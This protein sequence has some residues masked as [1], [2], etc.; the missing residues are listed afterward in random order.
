MV[1]FS[2]FKARC[3]AIGKIMSNSVENPQI[4]DIQKARM[5]ELEGKEKLTDKQADELAALKVK[6]QN[7]TRFVPS[8]TC[9][10]YMM[11]VYAWETERMVPVNKE[12]MDVQQIRKGKMCEVEGIKLLIMHDLENYQ[13]HKERISNDYLTGEIDFY[14]GPSVYKA[15]ILG[16]AKNSWDYPSFLKKIAMPVDRDWALQVGGYGDITGAKNLFLGH[17]LVTAPEEIKNELKFQ[18]AKKMDAISTES[19]DFLKEWA[20][21]DRSLTF[22]H[23][24]LQ[25]RV[26]KTPVSPWEDGFRQKV[27]DRVKQMR[28]WLCEFHEKR[29]AL[30]QKIYL[31]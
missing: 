12:T 18:L 21:F 4:T 5:S 14:A 20:V 25:Y 28:D 22:D 11:E 19:P 2:K 3:S 26:H 15:I 9:L 16:D 29:E 27:Y 1:D 13:M 8:L 23:M 31:I 24:P 10:E 30:P 7:S 6:E 17:C